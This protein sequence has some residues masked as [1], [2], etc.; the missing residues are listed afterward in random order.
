MGQTRASWPDRQPAS[1][2]PTPQCSRK[3]GGRAHIEEGTTDDDVLV[4][5]AEQ[6]ALLDGELLVERGDLLHGGDLS[7]RAATSDEKGGSAQNYTKR[8]SAME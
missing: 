8:D 2:A 5:H 4:G 3:R 1:Q 7:A 6:V